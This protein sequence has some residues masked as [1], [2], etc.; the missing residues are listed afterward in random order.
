MG[1]T[2]KSKPSKWMTLAELYT[3]LIFFCYLLMPESKVFIEVIHH[4]TLQATSFVGILK[5]GS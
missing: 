4:T 1:P 3:S 5:F 2:R